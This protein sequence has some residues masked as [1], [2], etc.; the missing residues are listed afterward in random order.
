MLDEAREPV[1]AAVGLARVARL[2]L[3]H[4]R[5][6]SVVVCS[7][8]LLELR[9]CCRWLTQHDR[10]VEGCREVRL[11]PAGLARRVL[12]CAPA[13]T[14]ELGARIDGKPSLRPRRLAK[15]GR[16]AATPPD[17]WST[18]AVRRR[19][20]TDAVERP[21]AALEAHAVSLPEGA[22]DLEGFD[23]A[24]GALMKGNA[25]AFE[26]L[27]GGRRVAGN[28]HPEDEPTFADAIHGG[29]GMGEDEWMA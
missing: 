20:D 10:R 6:R 26:L 23:T 13:V 1:E 29:D 17:R 5:G 19:T 21:V 11:R 8:E 9:L 14:E 15:R 18:R 16:A 24:A 22:A 2:A 25:R 3:E 27:A 28:A 4:R 12:D 7:E